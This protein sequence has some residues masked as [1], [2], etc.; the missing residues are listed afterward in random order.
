MALR[1]D[2]NEQIIL[3]GIAFTLVMNTSERQH[4]V[5]C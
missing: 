5:C 1:R 3:D 2:T 4:P